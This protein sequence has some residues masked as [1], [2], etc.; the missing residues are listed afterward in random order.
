VSSRLSEAVEFLLTGGVTL[1]LLPLAYVYRESVG[2][3]QS[4]LFLGFLLFHAAVVINNP[5]FAVTYLLFYTNARE[6]AFGSSYAAAQRA[7]YLFAGVVVPLALGA[8]AISALAVHSA[9]SLGLMIQLMFLLVGFHYVK[10]G[11]GVLTILSARRGVRYEPLER[12]VV[13]AHCFAAWL[14]GRTN[15]PDPGRPSVV[16]DVLYTSLPHPA[17]LDRVTLALFV[18]SGVALA[19]VLL[20]KWRREGRPPPLSPLAGL[21]V[22]VWLWTA[23]SRIDPLFA[24]LIP[25]LHSIQ[26]LY[27]VWLLRRN[28][29]R[30]ESGPPAFR[31]VSRSLLTLSLGS[32]ALGW[33]LF[34]GVPNLFDGLF[35][36]IDPIDPLGTTP[37]LA[38]IGTFVNLHHYFMDWV[39]WRREN[40]EVRYL[41]AKGDSG[42]LSNVGER[43]L[44]DRAQLGGGERDGVRLQTPAR[45]GHDRV[46]L[47]ASVAAER[48]QTE[49]AAKV[50]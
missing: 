47:D 1:L 26:Y 34:R 29:A 22:T 48:R 37:Y 41:L 15:P 36:L 14:Y 46:D 42:A 11:F 50:G 9:Q 21:L 23:F 7:R 24:Y 10:Q 20:G 3:E 18:A 45:R 13:L 31:S 12:R 40:P 39:I 19:V 2:L 49:R 8:W 43:L 35:V 4:E 33:V 16:D 17:G 5:H 6:R 32:L 25:A 28:Q 27:F 44:Q 30:E 38:A